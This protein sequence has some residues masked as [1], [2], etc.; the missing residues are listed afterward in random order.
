M[1]KADKNMS[2]FHAIINVEFVYFLRF[3]YLYCR[4]QEKGTKTGLHIGKWQNQ[5]SNW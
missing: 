1:I 4:Q 5:V 3:P 2:W